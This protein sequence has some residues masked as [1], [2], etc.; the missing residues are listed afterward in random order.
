MIEYA[1]MVFLRPYYNISGGIMQRI[2]VGSSEHELMK[3]KRYRKGRRKFLRR[4]AEFAK[5]CD[6]DT[7][8][9]DDIPEPRVVCYL[10]FRQRP[11][12]RITHEESL[13]IRAIGVKVYMIVA[14]SIFTVFQVDYDI[15]QF[16][17]YSVHDVTDSQYDITEV[18][19]DASWIDI[20]KWINQE[21][22]KSREAI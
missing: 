14:N 21:K 22:I 10:L 18:L 7:V 9:V 11:D 20:K 8:V 6:V 4:F 16:G 3:W 17:L 13:L 1:R 19:T 2:K 15:P 12:Y 5:T